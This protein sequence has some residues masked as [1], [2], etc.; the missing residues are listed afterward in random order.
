MPLI[1][2]HSN[3]RHL[4][5]R[6]RISGHPRVSVN[7]DEIEFLRFSL[8]EIVEILGISRTALYRKVDEEGL[9]S[10]V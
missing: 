4:S 6:S 9:P 8:K 2:Q 7:A 1:Y 3:F 10:C 5:H